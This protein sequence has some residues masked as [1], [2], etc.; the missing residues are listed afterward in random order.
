MWGAVDRS[1]IGLFFL[2]EPSRHVDHKSCYTFIEIYV[3][4]WVLEIYVLCWVIEIYGLCWVIETYVSDE[5]RNMFMMCWDICIWL[6]TATHST[7]QQL[8]T[9]HCTTEFVG[10]RYQM[11]WEI[12]VWWVETYVYDCTLQHTAPYSNS[13]LHTA[14]RGTIQQHTSAHCNTEF[15]RCMFQMSCD[16]CIWWVEMYGVATVSR[17]LKTIG[18]FCKRTLQKRQYSAQETY[19]LKE[20]TNRSHPIC[21]WWMI[22]ATPYANDGLRRYASLFC[23][24]CFCTHMIEKILRGYISYRPILYIC[25]FIHIDKSATQWLRSMYMISRVVQWWTSRDMWYK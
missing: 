10:Y 4:C 24:L 23:A 19:N 11:R 2:I 16:I 3:L 25:L 9:A 8:I 7:I 6:H 1:K 20:P 15:L 13:L 22:V 18:L 14:T 17:L 12:C 5:L 21:I